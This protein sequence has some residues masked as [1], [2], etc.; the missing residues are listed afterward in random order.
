MDG[1]KCLFSSKF[2]LGM[3]HKQLDQLPPTSETSDSGDLRAANKFLLCKN[4]RAQWREQI[5]KRGRNISRDCHRMEG[6]YFP[7]A[8]DNHSNMIENNK[9]TFSARE[10]PVLLSNSAWVGLAMK[11]QVNS[12]RV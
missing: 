12:V 5:Q 10:L 8:P 3:F 6:S 11:K 2:I 9:T 1:Q 4:R 7:A